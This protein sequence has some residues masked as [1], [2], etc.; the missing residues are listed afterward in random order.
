MK[1]RRPVTTPA[2]LAGL[3]IL[4]AMLDLLDHYTPAQ[5]RE[6]AQLA[7]PHLCRSG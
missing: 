7:A 6:Y 4:L 1:R 5:L 3:H 2:L